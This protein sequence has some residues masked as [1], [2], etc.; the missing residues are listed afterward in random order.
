MHAVIQLKQTNKLLT[1]YEADG[2]VYRLQ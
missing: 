2:A 1:L